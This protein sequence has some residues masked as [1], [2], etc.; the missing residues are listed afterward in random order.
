M[1][2]P[3]LALVPVSGLDTDP[4]ARARFDT[5]AR[6]LEEVARDEQG[7]DH[8]AWSAEELRGLEGSASKRRRQVLAVD[9]DEPV[10]AGGIIA[11]LLDNEATAQVF[12]AVLPA[13]R[14]RGVGDELLRWV[15]GEARGLGRATLHAETQW[16]ADT[17]EDPFA[18]WVERHGFE[19]AQ[20]VL[21]SD[22]VMGERTVS[23]PVVADGYRLE[24]HVDVMPEADLADRAFLARRMSTDVP[25]GDLELAEEEWD[26]GRVR[27]EDERTRAMGRRVV[28]TFV[29]D[30]GTGR[31]VGYTS[32]QCPVGTPHL[33]FQ[34]DTLVIREHRGH[35]L[36]LA[37]KLANLQALARALP[38]V[39]VVR[40]WNAE[41]N[42][43]ML[44]VNRLLGFRP[45]GRLRAW[46]KRL[47]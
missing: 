28:S 36:G 6:L 14:R 7:E 30:L 29:R 2:P 8:D 18:G 4:T 5:W 32:I 44:A 26:E 40:T 10:G 23:V 38:E 3:D 42:A 46:Q 1:T 27:G 17:D 41:E 33:A 21:R 45:S 22:L 9:G 37:L 34:H 11:P 35:G 47:A 20:T 24:T 43:H 25:L 15:E 19:A 12:V 39:S 16:G 13:H 31:L